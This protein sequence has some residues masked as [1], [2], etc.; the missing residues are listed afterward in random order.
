ME[1]LK[2]IKIT[3]TS[4][5]TYLLE[6][7]E[8]CINKIL[9]FI[10]KRGKITAKYGPLTKGVYKDTPVTIIKPNKVLFML[11]YSKLTIDEIIDDL[12]KFMKT[13]L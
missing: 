9:D 5:K 7:E 2:K 1:C 11:L 13:D 6:V 10:E 3:C 8:D 12:R 4:S